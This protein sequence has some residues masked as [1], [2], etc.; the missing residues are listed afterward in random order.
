IN[1]MT[2]TLATFADQVTTVAREVGVE[3]RL[4][5]QAN[6]P[7]AAG[8]WKDLTGN[9]NLLADNLT[10][11]VRAIAEVA[12]A[13]TKGD[14]TRSVQV[15]AS[16][17]VAELKDYINTMI[18]N[19]RLTTDRN[20]EQDWLKTNL[21][22]FTGMLQGQRDLSTVGRMLLSELAPLVNAQQGVIYREAE[23][24]EGLVLLSTFADDGMDGHPQH[25]RLGDGL[26]GQCATEKKRMLVTD[27]PAQ[28]VP[29]R[30]GLFESVPQNVI[31]LP[32]LFEDRVKAVIELASLASFTV[33][34]LAFL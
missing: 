1:N 18:D 22:R 16:G 27:L 34:H 10:N 19:L 30:S 15:E 32:V 13:V 5:G 23:E 28:T 2:D 26:V 29:I 11:Q 14:L 21:A 25:L 33:S 31:V 17:E 12:T 3:G 4:G 20:K 24:S 7:G 8:T 6:V 9:V